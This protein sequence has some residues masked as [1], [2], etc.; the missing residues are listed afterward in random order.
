[1]MGKS[2]LISVVGCLAM[3]TVFVSMASAH[4]IKHVHF[5]DHNVN[6]LFRGGNPDH[7]DAF[8]YDYLVGR[9]AEVAKSE[10]DIDLPSEFYLIDIN[11]LDPNV[12]TELKHIEE[13]EKFFTSNATAGEFIHYKI[14]GE[15]TTPFDVGSDKLPSLAA[16]FD[17]WSADKLPS[18]VEDIHNLLTSTNH[19]LPLSL[20]IHCECGCDRT[21]EVSGAYYMTYLNMTLYEAHE[22]DKTIA[23]REIETVNL[24]ALE[25][26]CFYLKYAK[27]YPLTCDLKNETELTIN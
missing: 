25:W 5:V 21:G 4:K 20:Y 1:M 14:V 9:M 11:L 17:S 23:K 6:Y 26:Y 8:D 2:L 27:N 19:S 24:N 18:F 15:T 22:L 12:S 13:E 10:G 7:D 3:I 16:S